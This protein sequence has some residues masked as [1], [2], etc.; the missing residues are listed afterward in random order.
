[1]QLSR[2][3]FLCLAA[4]GATTPWAGALRSAPFVDRSGLARGRFVWQPSVAERGPLVVIV[5]LAAGIVHIF[6]G[7]ECI[8]ISTA[9]TGVAG[10]NTPTGVFTFL[11]RS[12]PLG[13]PGTG[14]GGRLTWGAAAVH[15]RNLAG[16]PAAVGI[17]RLPDE[18]AEL[19]HAVMPI[20][21]TL[22]V[23]RER[24]MVSSVAHPGAFWPGSVEGRQRRVAAS[25]ETHPVHSVHDSEV[26]YPIV[27]VVVSAADRKA[28]L[29]R[30]GV[31]DS[32]AGIAIREPGVPLGE[33][34]YSLTG[35]TGD[36]TNLRWLAVG[37][38]ETITAPQI[39]N[40]RAGQALARIAFDEPEKALAFAQ[41]LHP[42]A[43]LVATDEALQP[44]ADRRSATLVAMANDAPLR[45]GAQ[46]AAKTSTNRKRAATGTL[47]RKPDPDETFPFTF[48]W[49][50]GG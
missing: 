13:A 49:P 2:R 8:G 30:S 31:I 35:L 32:E 7:G 26:I 4:A 14:S 22:I 24:S 39:A 50:Y 17:V 25:V 3:V 48:Y 19:L 12:P 10:R 36:R 18:L 23:T 21:S 16:Y 37:L 11:D 45:I 27:S 15:A 34:V 5:S 33:Y 41:A 6:R 28:Y 44:Q 47:T 38:G 29:M 43:T 9:S 20:G 42:G 46:P 40:T 1:M